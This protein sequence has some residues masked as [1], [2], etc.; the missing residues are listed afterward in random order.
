M[1]IIHGFPSYTI[2][3]SHYIL[4]FTEAIAGK[5][6]KPWLSTL[7]NLVHT[8]P[9]FLPQQQ[10]ISYITELAQFYNSSKKEADW[11][12][13]AGCSYP[14]IAPSLDAQ[15]ASLPLLLRSSWAAEG[16]I[17]MLPLVRKTKWWLEFYSILVWALSLWKKKVLK[18]V[19]HE[20]PEAVNKMTPN[21]GS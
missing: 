11:V 16:R 6:G 3:E 14:S 2:H 4:Y 19:R 7:Q 5:T 18:S 1:K 20:E 17:W 12:A 21:L 15:G 8:L 9:V 13:H 10:S